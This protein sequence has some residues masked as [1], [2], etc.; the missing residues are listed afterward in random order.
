[1]RVFFIA[2]VLLSA[3]LLAGCGTLPAS[4]GAYSDTTSDSDGY[5]Y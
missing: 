5:G 4:T 3:A 2:I 1:M